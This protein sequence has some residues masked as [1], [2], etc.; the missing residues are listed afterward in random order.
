MIWPFGIQKT[1]SRYKAWSG[2]HVGNHVG[3]QVVFH[4]EALV[5]H[6][7]LERFLPGV[8]SQMVLQEKTTGEALR[9]VTAGK[10]AGFVGAR[11][12]GYIWNRGK[13]YNIKNHK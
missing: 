6:G 7:T 3:L 10:L 11:V 9:T 2:F 1:H 12:A 13:L 4:V 8:D 5:A